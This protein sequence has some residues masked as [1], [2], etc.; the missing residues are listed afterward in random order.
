MKTSPGYTRAGPGLWEM[1]VKGKSNRL[2][3]VKIKNSNSTLLII[4]IIIII[5]IILMINR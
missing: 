2:Q 1:R 5:L 4:V 3:Q